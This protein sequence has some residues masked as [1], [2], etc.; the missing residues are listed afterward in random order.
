MLLTVITP[1]YNGA[2]FIENCLRNVVAQGVSDIEHLVVDGGSNDGTVEIVRKFAEQHPHV[3]ID[4]RRDSGQS[5]AMNRGLKMARGDVIS[6]LN[7]DDEYRPGAIR[8]ALEALAKLPA[9]GFVVGNCAVED[10]EGREIYISVP[11]NLTVED[12]L[13]ARPGTI[14]PINPASYFY[15]KSIH[16]AVGPFD[17]ADR[18]TMDLDFLIRAFAH[19]RPVHVNRVWATFRLHEESKTAIEMQKGSLRAKKHLLYNRYRKQLSPARQ[20]RC[21]V[22]NRYFQLQEAMRL[23]VSDP[24]LLVRRI[25]QRA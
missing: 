23:A 7:A 8:E 17:L 21:M 19:V 13:I 14:F 18:Q 15:H 9:P 6:F 1:V 2:P 25:T 10:D 12:I 5:D 11:G 24:M 22:L 3:R 4:S 20:L 16:D